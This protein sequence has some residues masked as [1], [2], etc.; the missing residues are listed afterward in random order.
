MT[1]AATNNTF[2]TAFRARTRES[3][4][5]I[6]P[7]IGG[8]HALVAA[9]AWFAL[10]YEQAIGLVASA[11]LVTIAAASATALLIRGDHTY[12][13][14][15]GLAACVLLLA[16]CNAFIH[17]ASAWSPLAVAAAAILVAVIGQSF[18]GGRTF[19]IVAAA[20]HAWCILLAAAD[21]W[22]LQWVQFE[23]AL[24]A[25]TLT[26]WSCYHAR[27]TAAVQLFESE[28]RLA[29][30]AQR[31]PL[32]SLPI[33][34]AVIDRLGESFARYRR[35]SAHAFGL[36][37]MNLDGFRKVNEQYGHTTG[38]LLLQ[39]V[40]ER[41]RAAC[42]RSDVVARLGGDEFV[43]LLDETPTREHADA[44]ADRL[45]GLCCAPVE[46]DGVTLEFSA[47]YGVVWA[48]SRF[49]SEEAMLS[50]AHKEMEAAKAR[51]H[52]IARAVDAQRHVQGG[53]ESVAA[54]PSMA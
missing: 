37:V 40:A 12:V 39:T 20:M 44:G 26:A 53:R 52:A 45:A 11:A 50:A 3:L 28:Q 16:L 43:I 7:L 48:D 38:D 4:R 15:D 1:K 54:L 34:A 30:R 49:E 10:P 2:E 9:A 23:T 51:Y 29:E 33:R 6:L 13:S 35:N 42:R 32:T 14:A 47:T 25:G 5:L 8:L 36:C 41:L 19:T 27:R 31:D 18:S 46:L 21:N 22:S 24:L 17:L